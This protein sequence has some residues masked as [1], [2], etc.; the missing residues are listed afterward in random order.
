ML[1]GKTKAAVDGGSRAYT[2]RRGKGVMPPRPV[3][4]GVKLRAITL[5][6]S[7]AEE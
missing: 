2:G 5:L 4:G 6:K 1:L 7:E 3:K